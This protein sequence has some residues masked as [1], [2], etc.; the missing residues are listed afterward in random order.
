MAK[1]ESAQAILEGVKEEF[2]NMRNQFQEAIKKVGCEEWKGYKFQ[3]TISVEMAE[4]AYNDFEP[5]KEDVFV[6]AYPKT[7]KITP[8]FPQNNFDRMLHFLLLTVGFNQPIKPAV[9][10]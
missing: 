5:R 1:N 9:S 10:R 3:P 4:Y 7:G 2:A 6:I 8:H